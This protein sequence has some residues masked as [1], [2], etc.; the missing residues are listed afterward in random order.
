MIKETGMIEGVVIQPLKQM[1]DERGRV[2][3]M[4]RDDS[5]FFQDLEKFIFPS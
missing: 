4:L 2:M 1:A 3:H 5:P